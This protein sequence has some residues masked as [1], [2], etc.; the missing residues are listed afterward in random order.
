MRRD[1]AETASVRLAGPAGSRPDPDGWRAFIDLGFRRAGA[2]T[3]LARRGGHGP[4]Q[5][6]RPFYP[7]GEGVCHAY[8][9]HPPGGIVAG[10]RLDVRIGVEG[11]ARALVTT[12]A[13]GKFYRSDGRGAAQR[14]RLTVAAGGVL[15]WLPQE[16]IVFDGARARS[17]LQVELEA[18]GRFI[19]WD[20]VC[21][22]RPAAGESLASGEVTIGTELYCQG[23]PLLIEHARL[24][25]GGDMLD[26]DWGLGGATAMG[27]LYCSGCDEADVALAR[28][29]IEGAGRAAATLLD[30]LLLVRCLGGGAEAVRGALA[31]VWRRLRPRRLGLEAAAPRIWNT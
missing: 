8:L 1:A 15:E 2:R 25:G 27:T 14:C 7:E 26:S 13:A 21:L 17:D 12:P 10:D 16:T 20:V 30:G 18:G 29:A 28:E 3:V 11:G 31:G 5:V 19:G 9:L 24:K 6:Q 23:R 4:L 22:G